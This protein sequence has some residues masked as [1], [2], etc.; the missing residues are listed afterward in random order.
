M[1]SLIV[2]MSSNSVIGKDNKLPWSIPEDLRYFKDITTGHTVI[3]GRKT[4]ESIGKALPNRRNIILTQNRDFLAEGCTVVHSVNEVWQLFNREEEIFVIGGSEIYH[5]FLP[6]ASKLYITQI[7]AEIEGDTFFPAFPVWPQDENGFVLVSKR[8]PLEESEYVYTFTEWE[9]CNIS[10]TKAITYLE[11]NTLSHIDMLEPI[12]RGTAEFLYADEDGVILYEKS[13]ATHMISMQ[14]LEKCKSLIQPEDCKSL[15]VH[16]KEIADWIQE[17]CIFAH[18]FEAHQAAY[19]AS[20]FEY[21]E[22]NKIRPLGKSDSETVCQHYSAMDDRKYILELIERQQLWG[23]YDEV[24]ALV[25]FIG[26]HLEGS[27]GLLEVFPAFR[28]EGYGYQL[29]AYLIDYFLKRRQIPFC[30]VVVDNHESLKLQQRL[31]LEIS[32]ESTWWFF[33]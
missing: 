22:K 31:G 9:K 10:Y 3:M 27:M 20:Q 11:Q 26:V 13:S 8:F 24:E 25:G 15:A 16:Q 14:D 2:A 12:R 18:S 7:H 30:Q 5:L 28:R 29:E 19:L 33:N 4:Y 1:I 23:I 32:E 6:F 17:Q 21:V